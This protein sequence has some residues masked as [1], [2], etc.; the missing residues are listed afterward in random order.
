M[1]KLFVLFLITFLLNACADNKVF[2]GKEY[3]TY[4]LINKD[5]IKKP[6]VQYKLSTGNLVWGIILVETI[7]MPIY[8]F[9]FSLWEPVAPI[10]NCK[11]LKDLTS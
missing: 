4:G 2:D 11:E 3:E 10:H 9:G 8:F 5:E 6:C 7:L 1:K